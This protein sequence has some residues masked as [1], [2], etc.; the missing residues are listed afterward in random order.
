MVRNI[1]IYQDMRTVVSNLSLFLQM[2]AHTKANASDECDAPDHTSCMYQ[3]SHVLLSGTSGC[4]AVSTGHSASIETSIAVRIF[5]KVNSLLARSV[6]GTLAITLCM[7]RVVLIR[8]FQPSTENQHHNNGKN[9]C[10]TNGVVHPVPYSCALQQWDRLTVHEILL[11]AE[12]KNTTNVTQRSSGEL[13]HTTTFRTRT[14]QR[15]RWVK[16]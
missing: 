7:R 13:K 4:V 1:Y 10:P 14:Y 11:H 6:N 5:R 3:W 2:N 12:P 8:S 16:T 9:A 15:Q